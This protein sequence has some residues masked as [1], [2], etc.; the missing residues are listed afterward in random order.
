MVAL[1]PRRPRPDRIPEAATEPAQAAYSRRKQLPEPVF[2]ILKEQQAARHF[3]LRGLENVRSEWSLLATA[4]NLRTL[5]RIWQVK[6][7][8]QPPAELGS[9]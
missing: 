4:F 8:Q 6:A 9:R 3:L 1:Q 2:G 7:R 5:A